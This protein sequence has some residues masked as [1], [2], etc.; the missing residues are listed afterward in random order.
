MFAVTHLAQLGVETVGN[1]ILGI[2]M[3]LQ[4]RQI[5]LTELFSA[6]A[7]MVRSNGY[8]QTN[9]YFRLYLIRFINILITI[10]YNFNQR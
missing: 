8:S 2:I 6:F 4:L 9:K 10:K 7:P 1:G 5:I 3:R